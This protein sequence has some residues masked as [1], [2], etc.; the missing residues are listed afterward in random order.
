MTLSALLLFAG[1]LALSAGTPGPSI[2]ALVAQVL[3][4]GARAVLPFL[5]AMWIGEAAWLA[6]AIAGLSLLAERMQEAFAV[7]RWAGIL[8]LGWLAV[9]T[10]RT[11]LSGEVSSTD[12][13]ALGGG[14]VRP[15]GSG[16]RLFLTGLALTLGN[17]KIM[18][19]YLALLPSL[20]DLAS[21]GPVE[22]I[23]LTAVQIAVM[24][25]LDLAWAG[26]AARARHML[27]SPR[28]LGRIRRV[29]AVAMGGA[30]AV[31]AARA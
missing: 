13:A 30:A 2:V 21:V 26:L 27:D 31:M 4:R 14:E 3:T 8:Y 25:S 16:T 22:W 11:P 1:A 24:A 19:F 18:V 10:W 12:E 5:A 7:L 15:E 28:A 6:A 29:S 23:Q 9:K 20:I 17:P